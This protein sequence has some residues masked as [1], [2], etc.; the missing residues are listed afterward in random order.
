MTKRP[1]KR[2]KPLLIDD[3]LPLQSRPVRRRDPKQPELPFDLMP[4]RVEPCLAT[5]RASPPHG[6]DWSYEIKWDGYRLAVHVEP[7]GVRVITRGGKDWTHR[8]PG[9][10]EAAKALDRT[11]I[12]DGEAVILDEQGRSDF[13]LLQRSLGASGRN[14][15]KL[16]S[17]DS[18]LYAFDLLYLDGHDLRKLDY[19]DRR[20]LLEEVLDG[21]DGAIRLSEEFDAD[22][23]ALLQHAC[24][25][26]LEGIIAKHRRRPYRSGRQGDWLK[27]KCIQSDSFIVVGYEPSTALAGA[28]GS[29][30]LAAYSGDDLVYVGS[31]GTGF[32]HDQARDLKVTLDKLRWKA[33]KPPVD[34]DGSR[35]AVWVQPT[36]ITEIEYRAWTGDG[37]L[38]HASYKGLRDVQ[39]NAE[40]YQLD[41]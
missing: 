17:R 40:I 33:K 13:G 16:P 24:Q 7:S 6:P 11:M 28:I 1:R 19:E 37:K 36:L 20:E 4:E 30:L 18:I 3:N 35:K 21:Q 39:D 31:V 8:F 38:R 25:L 2:S 27:I 14:G 32:K 9:I 41:D 12:L 10:A 15:G 26:G 5:L 22:P 29:L 23:D 34:Y